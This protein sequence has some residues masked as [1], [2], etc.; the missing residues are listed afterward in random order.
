LLLEVG[1]LEVLLCF[2]D[3]ELPDDEPELDPEPDEL[4]VADPPAASAA[5]VLATLTAGGGTGVG[6]TVAASTGV[7]A[8]DACGCAWPM[9]S[10]SWLASCREPT[11]A[12]APAPA[13]STSIPDANPAI[14]VLRSIEFP[15]HEAD[16]FALSCNVFA[17]S[18]DMKG[19]TVKRR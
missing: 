14:I 15:S 3:E 9:A 18:A 17:V 5:F 1:L 2:E 6:S 10:D 16:Y 19:K 8:M 13:T 4:R 7:V 12:T 11:A